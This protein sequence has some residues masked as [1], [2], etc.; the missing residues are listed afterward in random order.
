MKVKQIKTFSFGELSE[1]AKE[2]AMQQYSEGQ[3][4]FLLVYGWQEILDKFC[5]I[6]PI[7]WKDWDIYQGIYYDCNID[8]DIN[9]LEGVR[10]M[11]YIINNFDYVL[12]KGRFIGS[13]KNKV[14]HPR[15]KSKK[16]SNGKYF[17]AYYSK[18]FFVSDCN[19][20]GDYGDYEIL[21]PIYDFLKNP[22][23]GISLSDILEDCLESWLIGAKHDYEDQQ[24]EEYLADFF[25]AND[26]VFLE[27]GEVFNY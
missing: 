6:F 25:N 21:K 27:N 20:T 14:Y 13:I 23:Y 19:L 24:S 8:D 5:S 16:L 9:K 18:V 26:Y 11:K 12:F 17:N 10:L 22:Q 2:H 1:E 15:I 7:K 3:T 4:E